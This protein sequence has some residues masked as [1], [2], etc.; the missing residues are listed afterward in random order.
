MSMGGVDLLLRVQEL[1][2]RAGHRLTSHPVSPTS[3]LLCEL[4]RG[5]VDDCS[6]CAVLSLESHI[7]HSSAERGRTS[8]VGSRCTRRFGTCR[9]SCRLLSVF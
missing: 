9:R 8:A 2:A 1:Y 4:T 5:R 6:A 7:L 3:F